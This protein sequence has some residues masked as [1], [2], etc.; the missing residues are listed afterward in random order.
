MPLPSSVRVFAKSLHILAVTWAI[1]VAVIWVV[2]IRHDQRLAPDRPLDIHLET[3]LECL[4]PALALELSAV[5]IER[6][7]GPPRGDDSS[8][9]WVHALFWSVLPIVMLLE[10]VYLLIWPA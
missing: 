10:T 4:I 7:A 9:E 3:I 2:Q 5:G 6:W 8:R 1:S